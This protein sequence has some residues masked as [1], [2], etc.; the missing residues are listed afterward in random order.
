MQRVNSSRGGG[1]LAAFTL[2]VV[3]AVGCHADQASPLSLDHEALLA[4]G[5]IPGPP[6]GGGGRGGGGGGGG[7]EGFG[8]NLSVPVVLANGLGLGGLTVTSV[9]DFANTGFRPTTLDVAALAELSAKPDPKLPFWWS[10]NAPAPDNYFW[11]KTANVWQAQWEARTA[12]TVTPVVVDW[13]DNLGSV[14]FSTNSTI[15][16]EHVLTLTDAAYQLLGY[17]M[18]IV[19]NP[20]SPNEEQG[21]AADGNQTQTV[22]M[23]PTVFT[24]K[25]RLKLQKLSGEGGTVTFTYLDKAVDESFGVDGPG[26]YSAE[27]NVGGKVLFGYVWM[28]KNVTGLPAGVTLDGWWR[29]TFSL[30]AGSGVSFASLASGDEAVATLDGVT[31]THADIYIGTNRGGG[32]T[33]GRQGGGGN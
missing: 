20:S 22:A 31:S 5:G 26:G 29:I 2:A 27:I 17:P 3:M 10:G 21:I 15:R 9:A 32:G 4:K 28:V 33:G 30:D 1:V 24:S 25:A 19:V 14:T 7:D 11:Q 12:P 18:D 23:S 6:T 16:V 8:N 13:G